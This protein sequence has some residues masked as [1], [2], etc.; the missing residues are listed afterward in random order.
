[1]H[2]EGVM[3][4]PTPSGD[5]QNGDF[6]AQVLPQNTLTF[7]DEG[8]YGDGRHVRM[9]RTGPWLLVEDNGGCGGSG[10][11]FT[12]LYRPKNGSRSPGS[13]APRI[14][15]GAMQSFV[16][17]YPPRVAWPSRRPQGYARAACRPRKKKG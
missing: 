17:V 1:M 10:V 2:V 9:Q 16:D 11:T 3:T 13:I 15:C 8:A 12:G 14:R 6:K 4:L 5:F 7:T